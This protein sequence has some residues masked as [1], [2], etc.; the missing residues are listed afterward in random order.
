MKDAVHPNEIRDYLQRAP[1]RLSFD[2]TRMVNHT[3]VRLKWLAD[4]ARGPI[5]ERINR[6]AGI[7]PQWRPFCNP[8]WS[9]IRRHA[10]NE[11]R[12]RGSM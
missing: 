3:H 9:S 2:G 12:K 6:R 7:E 1:R 4:I 5:D 8:V 10:R 11:R